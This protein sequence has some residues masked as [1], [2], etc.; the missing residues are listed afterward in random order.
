MSNTK[1]YQPLAWI[2]TVVL[3]IAAT[4]AA[5]NLYP[6]Y[7]YLFCLANGIWVMIGVLWRENS[8]IVLNSG[9]TL[10]YFAGLIFG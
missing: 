7:V 9:L 6:W 10:I 1:P 3:I 4:L 8:L 5:F 2:G